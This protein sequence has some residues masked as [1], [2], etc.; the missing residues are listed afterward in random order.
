MTVVGLT[1]TPQGFGQV[2]RAIERPLAANI[3][4][5]QARQASA[6]PARGVEIT[7][8]AVGVVVVEQVATTTMDISLR[9]AGGSRT[10]AELIVPVPD[11]AVVRTFAFEGS[12]SEPTARILPRDEARRTY[13]AIVARLRDPAL[14]EFVGYNLIRTSV[15][16]LEPYGTQKARLTYEHLLP[17]GGHRVDYVLPRSESLDYDIPWTVTVKIESKRPIA[18]VYS[19]SHPMETVRRNPHTASIRVADHQTMAPGPFRLSYLLEHD[20]VTASLMTYPEDERG[21][22][23]LLL[24]GLPAAPAGGAGQSAI[25][26]EVT[27]VLDRSGSMRGEKIEQAREAALQIIEALGHGETFNII[28]YNDSIDVFH[29][30][31]LVKNDAN[32]RSARAYLEQITAQG[33]TNIH[34]ALREALRLEPAGGTLPLVLF[35]TDGLPTVGE[36]SEVAI[37]NLAIAANPH[38]RRIFTFGVGV[39]V[40]TPLLDK[41]AQ[42]TRA[43][44]TYVLPNEDVEVK[45]GQVFRRLTG[46]VFAEARLEIEPHNPSV[47]AHDLIPGVIPDLFEGSQLV[48]LGKYEGSGPLTFHL[49]G[50]YLGRHRVFTYKFNLDNATRRNTFVPRLWASRKI[51]VL[52]DAIRQSGADVNPANIETTAAADPRVR[53]LVDEVVRLS[54]KFGILTEYTAFLAREGTDLSNRDNV[55]AEAN[56]NFVRRAMQTRS[57]LGA[58]NQSANASYQ[59]AQTTVN[60]SNEFWDENMQRVSIVNVQQVSD[61]AFYRRGQRWVDSRLVND[62]STIQPK[63]VIRFG[64][65]EFRELATRL[66]R[67]GR[68]GSVSL[69]GDILLTIDGEPVLI[70]GADGVK[71]SG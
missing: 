35:L 21:G 12:A 71:S 36:T 8:V 46:P 70:E 40:N 28:T 47:H 62:E 61:L 58:V 1:F 59:M 26:R 57:G 63:R 25:K 54:T 10:E 11:G 5:P 66:A 65:D 50:N 60:P 52:I 2:G 14:V 56:R 37:R 20:G 64:S 39:D 27:L 32:A 38:E 3:I 69:R 19:P 34:E 7:Q 43:T 33:G 67:Q 48:V 18:T 9:N 30:G 17:A 22:Y 4:V 45:V 53:E 6:R 24:G 15:F 55:L 68:Q 31:P 49:S 13:D 51:A 42:E 29:N 41:I 23:F 16:P 44:S